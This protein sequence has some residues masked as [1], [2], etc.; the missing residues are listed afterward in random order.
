[1]LRY[2]TDYGSPWV[3]RSSQNLTKISLTSRVFWGLV[4]DL[5]SHD[6]GYVKSC[7]KSW[8][9]RMVPG[10]EGENQTIRVLIEICMMHCLSA[11]WMWQWKKCL[12]GAGWAELGMCLSSVLE[13]SLHSEWHS[14]PFIVPY[15]WPSRGPGYNYY[16]PAPEWLYMC[17]ACWLVSGFSPV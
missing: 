1:M 14:I 5:C 7:A 6:R 8:T 16:L 17:Q 11:I 9:L 13:A 2:L 12:L 15:F 3:K 10:F 4:L